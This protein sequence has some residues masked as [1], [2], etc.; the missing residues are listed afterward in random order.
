MLFRSTITPPAKLK[1]VL[2]G[3]QGLGWALLRGLGKFP[4]SLHSC[5]TQAM[6]SQPYQGYL[7][8]GDTKFSS[9]GKVWPWCL[10][11]RELQG[12]EQMSQATCGVRLGF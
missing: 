6:F 4:V 3:S 9:V 10:Q 5:L 2:A 7:L 1:E 11:V 12:I 8:L